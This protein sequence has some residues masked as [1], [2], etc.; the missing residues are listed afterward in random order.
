MRVHVGETFSETLTMTPEEAKAFS[1]AARDFNP[2]HLDEGAAAA[3]RY[4]KL[5]VSG[6][7]MAAHL[8][9]LTATHFTARGEAVGLDFSL[10]FHKP[11]YA[12]EIVTLSWEVVEVNP[13]AAGREVVD[14]KGRV[15]NQKGEVAVAAT[16]R[17]M[18]A[19]KL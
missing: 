7:Q 1:R 15:L 10:R 5:I 9:A 14:L 13:T 2:L 8:M 18:V 19:E 12:D 17:I 4:G 11:V 3:S 16:G 6:T